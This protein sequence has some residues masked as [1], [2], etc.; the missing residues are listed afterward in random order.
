LRPLDV[1][2]IGCGTAGS[3][4]ALFLS[5][6]GHQVTVYERVSDPGPVGAGI[7]LQPTG[8][9]VLEEL[10]VYDAVV[11]RG[12]R[13]DR[14]LCETPRGRAVVDL[15]YAEVSKKLFGVGMHRGALFA[16]LFEAVKRSNAT[17]R[18]G[19][20]S[21]DLRRARP[22]G[23]QWI[24][25][26]DGGAWGPHELIVVCDGAKSQL[27]DDT[28]V[29]KSIAP[30]PWGALWFVGKD[31]EAG[32]KPLLHQIVRGNANML[33]LL[34]T[35]LGPDPSNDE[36]LVSLFWSIRAD[37][38]EAW[39]KAGLAAWKDEVRAIGGEAADVLLHQIEDPSQVLFSGYHDVE[40]DP[41]NT[42]NVVYLGDAAH[43]MSPQLG[44]GANLALWDAWVLAQ[45]LEAE[46]YLPRAL[47]LYSRTR[48]NH[49]RLYQLATRHLTPFFQGDEVWFGIL[50]D[51][52]MPLTA[53]VPPMRWLM[54]AV[55]TGT[56][57]LSSQRLAVRD[58]RRVGRLVV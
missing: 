49:L 52:F 6:A 53:V 17:L 16:G 54:V 42:S 50:R 24:V 15:A 43:A 56:V 7:T 41:W 36:P 26:E 39:K 34:P 51:L 1:G 57:E 46:E 10:G 29:R 35:G 21:R 33:G 44:Q 23:W 32:A 8:L 55:M 2:V 19:V 28:H 18:L 20:A 47:D 22:R 13:I 14:L 38:V 4:T 31:P 27:R 25:D 9:H 3:A 30:Y 45:S 37:R 40:M 48:S 5:R 58:P 11:S 12:A